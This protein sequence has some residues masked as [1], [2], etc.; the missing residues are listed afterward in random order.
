MENLKLFWVWLKTNDLP[1]WVTILF[2][3]IIWPLALFAWNKRT[4]RNIPNLQI[5]ISKGKMRMGE[6]ETDSLI[7]NFLNNTGSIIYLTNVRIADC[8]KE[9]S[10]HPIASRDIAE[11]S[12]ELKFVNKE[13]KEFCERQIILQTNQEN[14]TSL[15]VD[16]SL[17]DNLFTFKPSWWR[18]CFQIRKYFTLE[19][20]A[21]VG[22]KRY[23]VKTIY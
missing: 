6:V 16:L 17:P 23:K 11:L 7:L 1:N 2:S 4:V 8:S 15:G 9:F 22:G 14:C 12:H 20:I 10:V 5:S 3:L 13:K 18:K 21:M 19:Y